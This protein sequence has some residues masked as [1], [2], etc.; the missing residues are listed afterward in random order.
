MEVVLNFF[1]R[2]LYI[3]YFTLFASQALA[4]DVKSVYLSSC[5]RETGVIAKVS[6]SY[7]YVISTKGVVV[8]LP[9]YEI[10]GIA[11]Y[12]V[13]RFPAKSL[14]PFKGNTIQ[15]YQIKTLFK[16]SIQELVTGWPIS[17]SKNKLTFLSTAGQEITFDRSNIWEIN[18]VQTREKYNFKKITKVYD[19]LHPTSLAKCRKALP[20]SKL[21]VVS[22][23]PQDYTSDPIVI[24]R[25]LDQYIAEHKTI[26]MYERTQSFYAIP[27]VYKNKTTLGMWLFSGSRH[28]ASNNRSNNWTPILENQFSSGPFGYQHIF[29]TGANTNDYFIHEEPQTQLYYRFKADY[30]HLSY[31]MDPTLILMGKRYRWFEDELDKNDFK[32][33]DMNFFEIGFDFGHF[34]LLMQSASE[35]Q[36]GY[37]D[38]ENYVYDGSLSLPK[39]GLE[40]RNHKF[41]FNFLYGTNEENV[42]SDLLKD[43][44]GAEI[45]YKVSNFKLSA[46]RVN[47]GQNLSDKWQYKLSFIRRSITDEDYSTDTQVFSN[48]LEYKYS[49]KYI[50]K[51]LSAIE[52]NKSDDKDAQFLKLGLSANL[53]F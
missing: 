15:T 35:I 43:S 52:N 34:S 18:E 20:K 21:R 22:V 23:S 36:L 47:F 27:E 11:T 42:K 9:R 45:G 6:S 12:P 53:V 16:G 29:L 10:V 41:Y 33:N 7:L 50:F 17:F 24:K 30:F 4:L 48:E 5:K 3:C 8:K 40:F 32:L 39:I 26:Q 14:I 38:S 2:L 31:F 28:G 13:E 1:S 37:V 49:Y 46:L 51:M 19:F 25:S 44:S